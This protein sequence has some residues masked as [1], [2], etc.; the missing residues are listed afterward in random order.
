M[1]T[2]AELKELAEITASQERTTIMVEYY[3]I[4]RS[5]T[6]DLIEP[7]LQMLNKEYSSDFQVKY[8]IDEISP[9]TAP[10][11]KT[12]AMAAI[13]AGC[14]ADFVLL[15][16][17]GDYSMEKTIKNYPETCTIIVY[18]DKQYF[19]KEDYLLYHPKL[20]D[21][22]S[23]IVRNQTIGRSEDLEYFAAEYANAV[24]WNLSG[25][26]YRH[27]TSPELFD[28]IKRGFTVT[29]Y[30]GQYLSQDYMTGNLFDI[31]APESET[32]VHYGR[33]AIAKLG[34]GCPVSEIMD[35]LE[36][37]TTLGTITEDISELLDEGYAMCEC[38]RPVRTIGQ[39]PEDGFCQVCDRPIPGFILSLASP[40]IN[41]MEYTT[42]IFGDRRNN[43]DDNSDPY[44]EDGNPVEEAI[45]YYN[46]EDEETSDDYLDDGYDETNEYE[47]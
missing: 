19:S 36:E 24:G 47:E 37:V 14:K 1:A 18:E 30:A 22:I 6:L 16:N 10:S 46:G 33:K 13:R 15:I 17:F 40:Y 34:N 26:P 27:P 44:D 29:P 8:L 12:L 41:S 45:P 20:E 42:S 25:T 39:E 5:G 43:F 4:K 11:K 35:L 31:E 2:L 9:Y 32:H 28:H 3:G 38:G 21:D 23:A 7:V